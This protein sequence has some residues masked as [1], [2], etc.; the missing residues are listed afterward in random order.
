MYSLTFYIDIL[1]WSNSGNSYVKQSA[2]TSS[3]T[4]SPN[5]KSSPP[6][7]F[8]TNSPTAS[9]TGSPTPVCNHYTNYVANDMISIIIL[10]ILWWCLLPLFL[11]LLLAASTPSLLATSFSSLTAFSLLVSLYLY[12]LALLFSLSWPSFEVFY[13]SAPPSTPN[14][15]VNLNSTILLPQS[16]LLYFCFLHSDHLRLQLDLQPLAPQQVIR[17]QKLYIQSSWNSCFVI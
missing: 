7:S 16:W 4:Y 11:L 13:S 3:P 6:T 14:A 5:F 12:V 8:P 17:L 9:P 15:F 1:F 10:S 2:P